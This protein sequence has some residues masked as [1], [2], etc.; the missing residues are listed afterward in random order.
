MKTVTSKDRT[1]IA[2][3]QE[4]AGFPL[5]LVTG[6]LGVR[7]GSMQDGFVNLLKDHFTVINYDR[8]GRGDSGDTLPYAVER[9]IED[10]EALIDAIGVGVLQKGHEVADADDIDARTQAVG[11]VH[12]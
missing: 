11:V 6:A 2:Y 7:S 12:Q 9:E 3:D 1:T 10:I 8:R 4:G 5:V